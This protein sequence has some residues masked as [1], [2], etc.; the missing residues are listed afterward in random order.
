MEGLQIILAPVWGI[1]VADFLVPDE[2]KSCNFQ[3]LLVLGFPDTSQTLI[4]FE[5]LLFLLFQRYPLKKSKKPRNLPKL[6]KLPQTGAKM[7]W[8][9]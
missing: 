8:S 5:Q 1:L 9:F 6:P 4:S 3:N 7:I 2:I